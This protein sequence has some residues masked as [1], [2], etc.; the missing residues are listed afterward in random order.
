MLLNIR[1]AFR[2]KYCCYNDD[3]VTTTNI[4]LKIEFNPGFTQ[5]SPKWGFCPARE[6]CQP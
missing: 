5:F 4:C 2:T 6:T 1:Y 3:A